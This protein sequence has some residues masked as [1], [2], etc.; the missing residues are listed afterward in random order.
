MHTVVGGALHRAHKSP[1][2]RCVPASHSG[3]LPE[4]RESVHLCF[5][6]WKAENRNP[7]CSRGELAGKERRT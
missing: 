7:L 1:G 2:S 4:T 3:K 5:C 6:V